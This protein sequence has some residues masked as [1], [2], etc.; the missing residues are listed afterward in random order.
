MNYRIA[1][2][3][4]LLSMLPAFAQTGGGVATNGP[5]RFPGDE[6]GKP[7][8]FLDCSDSFLSTMRIP[9][10]LGRDL[11]Q[12]DFDRPVRSA[13]VNEIFTAGDGNRGIAGLSTGRD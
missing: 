4:L 6:R 3:Q 9:M 8:W 5:V 13:V 10:V 1:A 7:T 2:L 11:N 12:A